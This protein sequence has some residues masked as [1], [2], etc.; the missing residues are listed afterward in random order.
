MKLQRTTLILLLVALSLGT[1]VYFTQRGEPGQEATVQDGKKKKIFR[2]QENDIQAVTLKLQEQTLI[3]ERRV[4]PIAAESGGETTTEKNEAEEEKAEEN[5]SSP[6]GSLSATSSNWLI[7]AP[8]QAPANDAY[9]SYLLNLLATGRR[10]R[11]L[12]VPNDTLSE[13]GLDQPRATIEVR[14]KN[15]QTHTL[16]LGSANFDRTSLYA[17]ADPPDGESEEVSI[18]LVSLDFDIGINRSLEEW[19]ERQ[20]EENNDPEAEGEG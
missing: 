20:L 12:D 7:K 8:I 3:F 9:V 14:L 17:Q 13:Y 11:T 6:D 2:F 10:D 4:I 15:Q 5:S 18:I 16:L 1:G 19:R